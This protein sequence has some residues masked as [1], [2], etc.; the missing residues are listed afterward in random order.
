MIKVSLTTGIPYKFNSISIDYL[1]SNKIG[2]CLKVD[3]YRGFHKQQFISEQT[4]LVIPEEFQ[5]ITFPTSNTEEL[6]SQFILYEENNV[7][8]MR[9]R[10][11]IERKEMEM[12]III[13]EIE[14]EIEVEQEIE[15]ENL[16]NPP[17]SFYE[18]FLLFYRSLN[19]V[20]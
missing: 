11:E 16:V 4:G 15:K 6:M 5:Q 1:H 2:F 19:M 12:K 7:K 10:M 8:K 3:A 14:G 17:Q 18:S 9:A 13:E 20:H